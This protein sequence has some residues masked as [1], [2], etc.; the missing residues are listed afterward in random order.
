MNYLKN[1]KNKKN[2]NDMKI[3]KKGKNVNTSLY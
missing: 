1:M 3:P 2:H